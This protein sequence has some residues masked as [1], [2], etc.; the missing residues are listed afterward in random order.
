L[1]VP[2]EEIEKFGK[3]IGEA[4][5]ALCKDPRKLIEA[6]G[7]DLIRQHS[8]VFCNA[9]HGTTLSI[10]LVNRTQE[11]MWLAGVGDSTVL[12]YE[13][14]DYPDFDFLTSPTS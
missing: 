11:A 10:T 5:I 1:T 2:L 14:V 3:E 4:V 7:R 12:E 13:H 9:Y 8:E 6:R